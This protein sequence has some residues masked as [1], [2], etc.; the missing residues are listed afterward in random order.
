MNG[1]YSYYIGPLF[2]A[3]QNTKRQLHKYFF[4]FVQRMDIFLNFAS[5]DICFQTQTQTQTQTYYTHT[6]IPPLCL[7]INL[8]IISNEKK[9]VHARQEIKMNCKQYTKRR[10]Q[11]SALLN[12]RM[13]FQ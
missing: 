11:T 6:L 8:N 10:I 13:N 12:H 5:T 9:K 1:Q 2:D 3:Y 4:C 7:I